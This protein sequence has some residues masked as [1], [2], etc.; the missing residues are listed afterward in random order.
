MSRL[1][2]VIFYMGLN[3]RRRQRRCQKL[4]NKPVPVRVRVRPGAHGSPVNNEFSK[5]NLLTNKAVPSGV[6]NTKYKIPDLHLELGTSIR[7]V[8]IF[9]IWPFRFS[10]I[11]LFIWPSQVV[12]KLN[13]GNSTLRGEKF[14]N[15]W[16]SKPEKGRISLFHGIRLFFIL[17]GASENFRIAFDDFFGYLKKKVK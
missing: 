9:V 7:V 1:L 11:W 16:N 12:A 5:F 10:N 6:H 17:S 4:P 15:R 3:R 2:S 14:S 13:F 8:A